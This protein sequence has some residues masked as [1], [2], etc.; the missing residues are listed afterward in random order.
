MHISSKITDRTVDRY[1]KLDVSKLDFGYAFPEHYEKIEQYDDG[2]NQAYW[3]ERIDRSKLKPDIFM[4]EHYRPARGSRAY[5]ENMRDLACLVRS[6]YIHS[7]C[8]QCGVGVFAARGR[9]YCSQHCR[10][11]YAKK[12]RRRERERKRCE[13]CESELRQNIIR[14]SKK[15]CSRAC[16]QKAYRQRRREAKARPQFVHN[17]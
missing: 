5:K 6:R 12:E 2:L 17:G 16:Q 1:V 14:A 4:I 3:V 11:N 8:R 7:H 10:N 15:Y 13:Q 9:L